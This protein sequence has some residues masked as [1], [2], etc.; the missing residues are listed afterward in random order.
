MQYHLLRVQTLFP[1]T[2]R[3]GST[4]WK[5]L[6]PAAQVL[7]LARHKN[8]MRNH[9]PL[10]PAAMCW[11]YNLWRTVNEFQCVRISNVLKCDG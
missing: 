2:C 7:H 5:G 6:D 1:D 10:T 3:S 4:F 9:A 8:M 11:W